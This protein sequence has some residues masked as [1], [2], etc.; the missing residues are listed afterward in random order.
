MD[1]SIIIVNTN[2]KVLLKQTLESLFEKTKNISYE[3]IVAD[4][5]SHDGSQQMVREEFPNVTL[6]ECE[7][8]GFG[9]A[10]NVGAKYAKGKYLFLLNPDTIVLNN[11]VKILADF[12]DNNPKVGICGGNLFDENRQP[13]SS[14]GRLPSI[15]SELDSF[16]FGI[17]AK[18]LYGKNAMFNCTRQPRSVGYITGA[19]LM[20]RHELFLRLSGFDPDFFVYY[21]ET[22]LTFRVKKA[23]YAA[24]SVP[25]AE[26]I[27]LEGQTF[28][29]NSIK[30]MRLMYR[31]RRVYYKKT[32]S[33]IVSFGVRAI[34]MLGC[35]SRIL[36]F[37]IAGKKSKAK[38]WAMLLY[39]ELR[40]ESTLRMK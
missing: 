35:L 7:N 15:L 14:Y 31:G 18:I 28:S 37:V 22:E 17:L 27:H 30:R 34:V 11:A 1:V 4:N 25:Q 29:G 5:S 16:L 3:V 13:N 19:D 26:I 33:A 6:V 12:L 10:N 21:E 40:F 36:I 39:D 38:D 24:Y 32:S 2:T 20:I 9:H 23:G 8:K